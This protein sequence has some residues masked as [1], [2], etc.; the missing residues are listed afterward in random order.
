MESK[1]SIY[2]EGG[3][4]AIFG[5]SYHS[6]EYLEHIH[7]SILMC[8]SP[9]SEN[10]STKTRRLPDG[11]IRFSYKITTSEQISFLKEKVNA[12]IVCDEK[13]SLYIKRLNP[14]TQIEQTIT[15]NYPH[16]VISKQTIQKVNL[17]YIFQYSDIPKR[18][19]SFS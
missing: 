12:I 18:R 2:F 4:Y 8:L 6:D 9:L 5:C 11:D 19:W 15:P 10:L 17:N 14:E 3:C 13:D 1:Q 7:Q 16:L